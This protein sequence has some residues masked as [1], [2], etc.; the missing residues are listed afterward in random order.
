LFKQGNGPGYAKFMY[1]RYGE[2]AVERLEQLSKETTKLTRLDYMEMI[3]K[4]TVKQTHSIDDYPDN[5]P[6]RVWA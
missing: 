3:E 4:Y 6:E 5:H 1:S 2:G